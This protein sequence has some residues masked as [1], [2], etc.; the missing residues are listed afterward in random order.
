MDSSL[1][2]ISKM[3]MRQDNYDYEDHARGMQ[4]APQKNE[5]HIAGDGSL[6]EIRFV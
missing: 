3:H 1:H 6:N 2:E 5:G 4:T